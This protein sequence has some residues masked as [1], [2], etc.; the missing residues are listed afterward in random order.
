[1]ET[2]LAKIFD[3]RKPLIPDSNECFEIIYSVP[4]RSPL[5]NPN[6]LGMANTDKKKKLESLRESISK[7]E[8][9]RTL[10]KGNKAKL[11]SI[12]KLIER[13]KKDI[14]ALKIL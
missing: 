5:V 12:D 13:F 10:A 11:D 3:S 1:M 2:N 4:R 7:L 6:L 8:T 9:Q 14:Q